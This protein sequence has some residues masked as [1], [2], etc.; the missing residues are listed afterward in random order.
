VKR[1]GSRKTVTVANLA[2]LGAERLAAILF[3]VGDVQP[4]VKRRLR[5]ELAGAVGPDDLAVEIGKRLTAIDTARSRVH[6]RKHKEFVRDL[7]WQRAMIA[8]RLAE[9]KPAL[10]LSLL[11]RFLRLAEDVMARVDDSKGDVSAVFREAVDDIGAIAPRAG[12]DPVVLAEQVS[13]ALEADRDA[14]CGGLV[15]AALPALGPAGVTAL[16]ARLEAR[17]AGLRR[18]GP[19]L[20]RSLQVLADAAGDV[21][22]FIATIPA[23][24]AGH[25]RAGAQI[26][27]RLLAAGRVDDALAALDRSAPSAALRVAGFLGAA[28]PEAGRDDWEAVY[29][30]VLEAKGEAKT[31]Q[32]VRWKAFESRLAVEHL[33]AHL[34]RL[35]DFDDVVAEDRAMAHARSF[36]NFR[37]ALRFFLDWP[38]LSQAAALVL[39]R[40][41]EIDGDDPELLEPAAR[42][43]EGRHPLAAT[44]LLRALIEDTVKHRRADRYADARRWALELASLAVGLEP[45][46]EIEPHEAF[47]RRLDLDRRL[48]R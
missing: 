48:A 9:L 11:W 13:E 30:D 42:A 7:S 47:T 26:A 34:A 20:R 15:E 23:A 38:A 21:D 46:G 32:D 36:R 16:R 6:W 17:A 22:G 4:S 45:G 31:A 18:V 35:A 12:L 37:T 5:L 8:G 43:L 24:E 10:A 40:R 28:T 41:G 27:R 1:P 3:E 14:L 39:Q 29:L 25:P 19:Q 2:D 33:R 44:L